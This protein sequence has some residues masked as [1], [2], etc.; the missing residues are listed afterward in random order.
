MHKVAQE[1]GIKR[2]EY[3]KPYYKVLPFQVNSLLRSG[4]VVV[5]TVELEEHIQ[6]KLKINNS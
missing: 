2:R 6:C 1:C 4:A 5:S 3:T